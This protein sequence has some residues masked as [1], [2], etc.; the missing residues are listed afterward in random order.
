MVDLTRVKR[1]VS[2]FDSFTIKN[3]VISDNYYQR[4][5]S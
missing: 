5:A 4:Y 3:K 1:G 2:I